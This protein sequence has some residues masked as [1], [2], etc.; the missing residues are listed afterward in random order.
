MCELQLNITH[1]LLEKNI[2][3]RRNF[4]VLLKLK[5]VV[6]QESLSHVVDTLKFD[7]GHNISNNKTG[8]KLLCDFLRRE[9]A[10]ALI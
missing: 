6:K 10:N 1:F 5:A 2:T 9:E 7:I 8:Q 4:E 3:G